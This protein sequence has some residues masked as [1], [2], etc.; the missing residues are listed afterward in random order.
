MAEAHPIHAE[1]GHAQ[2]YTCPIC[3]HVRT[4]H[5][6]IHA[7]IIRPT[8]IE[9]IQRDHPD[10]KPAEGICQVCLNGYRARLV[11]QILENEKGEVTHLEQAVLDSLSKQELLA[12]NINAE[13][14]SRQSFGERVAD[15]MAEFGGSWAFLISFAA[16]LFCWICINAGLLLR[17]PFDPYPFILLN[18]ILSCLASI[19]APVIMMSQNRQEA[20]DRLRA[21]HDYQI[22]LKAEL[23]IRQLH[24]KMD[25][26][27]NH[28]WQHLLEIQAVQTELMQEMTAHKKAE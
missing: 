20:K 24:I 2:P 1:H 9:M 11:Q 22:N 8:L 21:E 26:L 7:G 12:Q 3:R 15:K 28:Q 17:H 16:V 27:L 13:F 10:W 19:Q 6:R 18:L 23:E 5:E 25:Q 4:H 14:A